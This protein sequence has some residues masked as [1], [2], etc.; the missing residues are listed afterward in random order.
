V[1]EFEDVFQEIPGFPPKTK[2]YLSIY[3]VPRDDTVS[4][5][6]YSMST[7]ELKELKMKLEEF[8]KKEYICPSVSPWGAPILFVKNKDG[9]LRLYY[10]EFRKLKKATVKNKYPLPKIDDILDQ[11]RGENIFPKIDLRSRYHQVRIEKEDTNNTTFRTMYGHYELVVVPFGISNAPAV[12]MF[13]MN[14]IFINYLDTFF[15]VLLDDISILSQRKSM[16][17]TKYWYFKC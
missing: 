7:I 1:Q 9:T 11:L 15:I 12:F 16:D 17:I 8:L 6:P 14:A 10:N 2:I 4:K 3:L 5:T 13:L